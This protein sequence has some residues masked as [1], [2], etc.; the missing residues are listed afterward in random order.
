M[1]AVDSQYIEVTMDAESSWDFSGVD[2]NHLIRPFHFPRRLALLR[3]NFDG[4]EG[5]LWS[6]LT[7]IFSLYTCII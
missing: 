2:A 7:I 6:I 3:Q 1:V 5:I 4:G